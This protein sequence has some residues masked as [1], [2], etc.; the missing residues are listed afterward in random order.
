MKAV[1][2][3]IDGQNLTERRGT[4]RSNLDR[5][6]KHGWSRAVSAEVA[7]QA[8]AGR[9]GH[10]GGSSKMGGMVATVLHFL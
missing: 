2:G 5:S 7:V 4:P 3:L 6:I 8:A 9:P 10:G 1:Q